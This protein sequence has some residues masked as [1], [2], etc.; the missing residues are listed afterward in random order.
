MDL[1]ARI[2]CLRKC[3]SVEELLEELE[4]FYE[5][6]VDAVK[7]EKVKLA[8]LEYFYLDGGVCDF[9]SDQLHFFDRKEYYEIVES[10]V[11]SGYYQGPETVIFNKIGLGKETPA[12]MAECLKIRLEFIKE[13]LKSIEKR[14]EQSKALGTN[15]DI[16]GL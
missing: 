6:L 15:V 9:V 3:S 8:D 2:D 1:G 5:E 14:K 4:P 12:V 11:R 16:V 10:V 7:E 13:A